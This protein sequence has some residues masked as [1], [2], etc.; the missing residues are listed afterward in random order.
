MNG[1][2][3]PRTIALMGA[4]LAAA[5]G[6]C[7]RAEIPAR[8]PSGATKA[9]SPKAVATF[10]TR[11]SDADKALYSRIVG[12]E[13]GDAVGR[14]ELRE[15]GILIHPGE[16]KP[17]SVT[18][19]LGGGL[20]RITFRFSM[21]LDAAGKAVPEAGTVNVEFLLDGKS[22]FKTY[23]DRHSRLEKT[24]DVPGAHTLVVRV[25]NA[26]GKS[27]WDWFILSVVSTE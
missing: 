6:A 11:A 26:N 8:E 24:L 18:F 12:R 3:L 21:P 25:D 22:A 20:K 17:T 27:W 2:R 5:I 1:Q 13:I 15:Q 10:S 9:A 23:V 14:V 4:V 7:R 16:K 19:Q